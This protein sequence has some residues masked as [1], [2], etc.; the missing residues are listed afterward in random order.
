MIAKI[1]FIIVLIVELNLEERSSFSNENMNNVK[2]ILQQQKC[3]SIRYYNK[4]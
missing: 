3:N 4:Y 2:D 1:Q